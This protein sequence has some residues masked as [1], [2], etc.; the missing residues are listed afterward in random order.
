ML[1]LGVDAS[2]PP[3]SAARLHYIFAL[4]PYIQRSMNTIVSVCLQQNSEIINTSE[5]KV[6]LNNGNCNCAYKYVNTNVNIQYNL[7]K[8][9]IVATKTFQSTF[10]WK[11][12]MLNRLSASS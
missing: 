8:K 12:I 6:D 10:I 3:A 9:Y 7:L 1:A 4:S 11:Y 5:G 2:L